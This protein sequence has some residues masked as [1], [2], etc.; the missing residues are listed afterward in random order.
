[1]SRV[2][3]SN[4]ESASQEEIATV[5]QKLS[6]LCGVVAE[7]CHDQIEYI[8]HDSDYDDIYSLISDID[9]RYERHVSASGLSFEQ[10]SLWVTTSQRKYKRKLLLAVKQGLVCNRC[11]KICLW[12]ELTPD[13]IIPKGRGGKATLW[14]SQLLCWKCNHGKGY[15]APDGRDISPFIY[16]GA[17]CVHEIPCVQVGE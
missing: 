14:N 3:E 11:D 10:L 2:S 5:S 6:D 12:E 7:V 16:Q 17:P 13:E 15:D 1:M 8:L 9:N 4:R